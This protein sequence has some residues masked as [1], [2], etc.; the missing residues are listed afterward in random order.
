MAVQ[1]INGDSRK[2][3]GCLNRSIKSNPCEILLIFTYK[4]RS[5]YTTLASKL[6]AQSSS[7]TSVMDIFLSGHVYVF[8]SVS[9]GQIVKVTG[10]VWTMSI[11][12]KSNFNCTEQ[13][14]RLPQ[15]IWQS[16][17][18][19]LQHCTTPPCVLSSLIWGLPSTESVT[20]TLELHKVVRHLRRHQWRSA[21][22][23]SR[24]RSP[25]SFW[26]WSADHA[27]AFLCQ[28]TAMVRCWLSACLHGKNGT[29]TS[30]KL[31]E[32]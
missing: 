21:R 31:P 6:E 23:M 5:T 15:A 12:Q 22:Q 4:Y 13:L 16:P 29:G 32:H 24:P 26:K 10:S 14:L 9:C 30:I 11:W 18:L 1:S 2:W 7:G 28:K 27:L 25:L 17:N 19:P 20:K 3:W 8:G